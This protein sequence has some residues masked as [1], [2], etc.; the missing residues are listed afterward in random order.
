MLSV[1]WPK[2]QNISH[3]TEIRLSSLQPLKR[4]SRRAVASH[5][6]GHLHSPVTV[7]DWGQKS[8]FCVGGRRFAGRQPCP[9]E[10]GTPNAFA[11]RF[12]RKS[13]CCPVVLRREM[14][15]CS[16]RTSIPKYFLLKLRSFCRGIIPFG[17]VSPEH[18]LHFLI[19]WKQPVGNYLL[20]FL[21]L[22]A[23]SSQVLHGQSFGDS[24]SSKDALLEA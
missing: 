24:I 9:G 13:T 6:R 19:K 17:T 12:A 15:A 23:C 10:R 3:N 20:Q 5:R 22:L 8:T 21:L 16:T 11:Y 1:I 18:L 4:Q 14:Q 2:F 7:H